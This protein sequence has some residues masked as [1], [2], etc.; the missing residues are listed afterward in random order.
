M[1]KEDKEM[2]QDLTVAAINIALEKADTSAK[3]EIK[4]QTEG[5]MPNIPGMDMGNLF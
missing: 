4:K 3:E 5:I 1:Q 2:L